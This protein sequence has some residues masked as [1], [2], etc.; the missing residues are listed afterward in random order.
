[1][2]GVSAPPGLP[3]TDHRPT[4]ACLTPEQVFIQ[5]VFMNLREQ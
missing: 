1:V 5:H 3:L 2:S 4:D